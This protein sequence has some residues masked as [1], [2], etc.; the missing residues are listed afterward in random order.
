MILIDRIKVPLTYLGG[1][2]KI[3]LG[4]LEVGEKQGGGNDEAFLAD[5]ALILSGTRKMSGPKMIV[6][7][8]MNL[9]VAAIIFF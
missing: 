5:R 9:S 6:E 8:V 7:L 4:A 1:V 2:Y 3:R